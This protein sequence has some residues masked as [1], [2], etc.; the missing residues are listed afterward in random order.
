MRSVEDFGFSQKPFTIIEGLKSEAKI[1][2]YFDT[3][4]FIHIE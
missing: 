4:A 3:T 1:L 2:D